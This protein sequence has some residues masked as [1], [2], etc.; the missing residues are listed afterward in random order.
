MLEYRGFTSAKRR[1]TEFFI[2]YII[3]ANIILLFHVVF[4][5]FCY[6]NGQTWHA[7]GW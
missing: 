6:R 7:L 1:I 2:F 5:L 4:L 3:L